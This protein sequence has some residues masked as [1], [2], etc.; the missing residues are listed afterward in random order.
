MA[1]KLKVNIKVLLQGKKY[2]EAIT[3]SLILIVIGYM[4]YRIYIDAIKPYRDLILVAYGIELI[5]II[6][7]LAVVK[8]MRLLAQLLIVTAIICGFITLYYLKVT[9]TSNLLY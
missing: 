3:Y 2:I 7:A 5:N 6:I 8:R 9:V 4:Q 1:R